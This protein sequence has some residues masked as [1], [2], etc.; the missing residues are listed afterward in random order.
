MQHRTLGRAGEWVALGWLLLKGYRIRHRNW[1]GPSGE[2]D[3]IVRRRGEIVFVEV[4]TRSGG[5]FGGGLGAVGPEKQ[6]AIIRTASAYLSRFG[7]WERPCRFDV[8]VVEKKES[9]F[10]YSIDHRENAFRADLGRLM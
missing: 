6:R 2:L 3:L 7:L 4:K 1:S 5:G 8:I 10:G 9:G